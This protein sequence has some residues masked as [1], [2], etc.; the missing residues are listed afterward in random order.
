[1]NQN[2]NPLGN[3]QIGPPSEPQITPPRPEVRDR[4]DPQHTE[5]DFTRDL[6]KATRRKSS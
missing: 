1:M 3:P 6:A 5:G 2:T 4:Q